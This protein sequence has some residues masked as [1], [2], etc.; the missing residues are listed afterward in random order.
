MQ[1]IKKLTGQIENF[2]FLEHKAW[3]HFGNYE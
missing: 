2:T 3:T 1:T